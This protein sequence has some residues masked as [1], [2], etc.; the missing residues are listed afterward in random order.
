M[1]SDGIKPF[2]ILIPETQISD[3]RDRLS[4]TRF[5]DELADS[6]WQSGAPLADVQRLANYWAESFDWRRAEAQL[7]RYPQFTTDLQAEGFETMS[8]HFIH[9]RSSAKD[10]IP[11][12]F[13]HG[14]PGSFYEGI[15]LIEPLTQGEGGANGEGAPKF[16]VVVPSIPNFGFSQGTGKR[17]FSIEHHAEIL[18]KLMLRLGYDRYATQGGDWGWFISRALSL[19]YPAHARAQHLNLDHA[20]KPT[21]TKHPLLALQHAL[22]PYTARE[23]QG[24]ARMAWFASEGSGYTNLQATR[25]Q[26]LGYL[27]ADSPT[28]LLAWI[29][30]KLHDWTDG[31]PWTDDEICTWIS[32][33]WFSTAGPAAST[34]LYHEYN[35]ANTGKRPGAVTADMLKEWNPHVKVGLAHFPMDVITTPR[36]WSHTQGKVVFERTHEKGGHFPAWERPDAIVDDLRQMFA[37]GA[38]ARTA[39]ES[40][41]V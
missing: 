7:N 35:R 16:H 29:Y 20:A 18:N 22:T 39:V 10:A 37:K 26:T 5:P 17:G 9:Q 38:E 12:L 24:L 25:P 33:Y 1:S 8:V 30:E 31:Y 3:L 14:W 32:V 23:K 40:E 2:Q 6:E 36:I 34:R 27:L 15:K 28:G 4:K 11:L 41:K 19:R 13:I 21:W